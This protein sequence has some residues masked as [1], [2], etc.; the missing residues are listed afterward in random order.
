MIILSDGIILIVNIPRGIIHIVNIPRGIILI[1]N[2]PRGRYFCNGHF[3]SEM[4]RNNALKGEL[5]FFFADLIQ[6][7]W[8]G[9]ERSYVTPTDL[10]K[11]FVRSAPQFGDYGQHDAQECLRFLL[12][13][14]HED[15][16]RIHGKIAYQE[17]KDIA[18]KT[19][20]LAV[21]LTL[22]L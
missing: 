22:T 8:T 9:S 2:I 20:A 5:A 10:R 12:D 14:L 17:L 3:R 11:L 6:K 16:N 13:G 21:T 15:L 7:L 4:N 18:G 19:L 1:V